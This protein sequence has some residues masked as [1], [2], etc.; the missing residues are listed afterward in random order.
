MGPLTN[1]TIIGN[2]AIVFVFSF[3]SLPPNDSNQYPIF[4]FGDGA[5][6]TVASGSHY[7]FTYGQRGSFYGFNVSG[8]SGSSGVGNQ[9]LANPVAGEVYAVVMSFLYGNPFFRLYNYS[10]NTVINGFFPTAA[11]GAITHFSFGSSLAHTNVAPFT[12]IQCA[13]YTGDAYDNVPINLATLLAASNTP[14]TVPHNESDPPYVPYTFGGAVGTGDSGAVYQGVLFTTTGSAPD[15]SQSVGIVF[16]SGSQQISLS[17]YL[18]LSPICFLEGTHILTDSGLVKVEDLTEGMMVQ[19][20]KHG[21]K[22]ITMVGKSRIFNSGNISRGFNQLFHYVDSGLVITGGHSVLRDDVNGEEL[23]RI[24]KSFGGLFF[25]EGKI[26]LAAMDDDTAIPYPVRGNFNIYNFVLAASN[27]HTN[28]GV[29]A[30]GVLV[31]SS[32][33]YWVEQMTPP[34]TSSVLSV[35]D[36]IVC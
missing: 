18:S 32:F 2:N 20:S 25:T 30:N 26:R 1:G 29:F 15:F 5:N 16:G 12:L 21:Y 22:A 3:A 9:L 35:C 34:P 33:P 10:T 31:E 4:Y 24:R 19:T 8:H 36:M 6:S 14:N 17:Q 13:Y 27:D 28:Y 11:P 7:E 23:T